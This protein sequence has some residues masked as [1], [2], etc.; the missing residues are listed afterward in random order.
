[1]RAGTN[2]AHEHIDGGV[3]G[4]HSGSTQTVLHDQRHL[5]DENLHPS[6]V[7]QD[8]N[9]CTEEEDDGHHLQKYM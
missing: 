7:V 4:L 6:Q 3:Q 2:P 5:L 1:M 8:G 9:H